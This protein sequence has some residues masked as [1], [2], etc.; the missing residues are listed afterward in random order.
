MVIESWLCCAKSGSGAERGLD[1][2]LPAGKVPLTVT[3]RIRK[4]QMREKNAVFL[5]PTGCGDQGPQGE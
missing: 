2:M 5:D 3:R 1:D 4:V